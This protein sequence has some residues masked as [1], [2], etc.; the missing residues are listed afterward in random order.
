MCIAG[1]LKKKDDM[2]NDNYRPISILAVLANIF[3]TI[4]ADQ[5]MDYFKYCF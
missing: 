2:I 4:I 1:V 5:L 3:E